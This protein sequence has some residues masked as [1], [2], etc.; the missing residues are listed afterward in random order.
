VSRFLES[1]TTTAAGAVGSSA[2]TPSVS[3]HH[4]HHQQLQA[5]AAVAAAH[6]YHKTLAAAN[7]F[8]PQPSS[9]SSSTNITNTTTNTIATTNNEQMKS[10]AQ[11]ANN[12]AMQ[13][14]KRR[15]LF[16]QAQVNELEKRFNKSRYLSAPEREMLAN[17]LNLSPTQVKIWFQNHRYK[18]KKAIKERIRLDRDF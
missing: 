13:R 1:T 14:R 17:G 9:S 7:N 5:N 16:S 2:I 6:H 12:Y 4:H 3:H 18:T 10:Y 8:N 15:I 11:F